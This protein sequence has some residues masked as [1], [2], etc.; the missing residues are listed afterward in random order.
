MCRIGAPAEVVMVVEGRL[1]LPRL[2]VASARFGEAL[3][4]VAVAPPTTDNHRP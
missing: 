3:D 4:I 1:I 2:Q